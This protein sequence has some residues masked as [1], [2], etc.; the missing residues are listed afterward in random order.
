MVSCSSSKLINKNNFI[1]YIGTYTDSGSEGIYIC[2]FD[3]STGRL[4]HLGVRKDV[5]DPSFLAVEPSGKFLFAV[6][7]INNFGETNGGGVSAFRINKESGELQFLNQQASGGAHPCHLVISN[8]GRFVLAGNYS[9]GNLSVLPVK[10]DGSLEQPSQI[11]QHTGSSI[12]Q[13]RQKAPHVHCLM[14][15]RSNTYLFVADL[16]TDKIVVYPFDRNKGEIIE[17]GVKYV[18]SRPG[19]GP[20]H[21]AFSPDENF[22]YVINELISGV[23]SYRFNKSDGSL[24]EIQTISTLP[25]EFRDPNTCAE[26]QVHPSGRFLYGSNR[27]HDSIAVFSRDNNNGKLELIELVP[28]EGKNPRNFAIDPTG[29]YLL[30]AN[31]DSNS[32]IS[33]RIDIKTGRLQ[34]IEGKFEISKPVCIAFL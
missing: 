24:I 17:S 16:G 29:N 26:I 13:R 10:K 32:I 23:T 33:F 20:R 7:E 22:L 11:I 12:N 21:L 18:S 5:T 30:V 14:M 34:K 27:G 19:A 25:S 8:D 9:G 1:A 3:A 6:N 2:R 31:Q 4:S 15:N 28:T